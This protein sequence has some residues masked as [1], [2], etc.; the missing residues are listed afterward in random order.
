MKYVEQAEIL[1]NEAIIPAVWQMKFHAPQ[2]ARTARPGQ[3]VN[4]HYD[5]GTTFLRRPFGIVDTSTEGTVTIIYRIVGTGTEELSR[6]HPGDVLNVEGPLGDGVFTTSPG[7]VLLAGGGVG[8]APLIFL[9]KRLDHPVVLVAGK[10]AAETFWTRFFEPYAED[11]YV[12]TDDG[13][14]GI[15]GFA[16]QALP[17]IFQEH[18][19]R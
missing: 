11:I 12:T 17:V 10:T 15:K 2:I 9:A 5:G 4:V 18:A 8:L 16:V 1:K 13:S 14:R 3:F 19:R 6:L 7:K